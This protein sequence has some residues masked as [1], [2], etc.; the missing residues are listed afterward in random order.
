MII[1]A[2]V[3]DDFNEAHIARH[4]VSRA[5][6]EQVCSGEVCG[7]ETYASRLRVIGA[8]NE[9]RMLTVILAP[10]GETTYYVVTARPASR[11]ERKVYDQWR[12]GE[13]A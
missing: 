13:A 11:A 5:E 1:T 6:V 7:A 4:D 2:L 9:G 3:W 12:G 8:T 10:K